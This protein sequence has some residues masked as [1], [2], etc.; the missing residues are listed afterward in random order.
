[1][2]GRLMSRVSP[3]VLFVIA[4]A[5]L[6]PPASTQ[7]STQK[8]QVFR[9]G[10]DVVPVYVNVR[11][12]ERGFVLDLTQD[13]F[14]L[15]DEGKP[16]KITQFTIAAQPL[17]TVVLIDG[18]ASMIP[19]F[20]RAVE[21]ARNFV[22][23]ML[24]EDR[25]KIG[26]FSDRVVLG[27]RFTSNRDELLKYLD[28][29]FNLRLGLDTHLWEALLESSMA[30]GKEEGKR[31]VVALT[32]GYNFVIP[33]GYLPPQTGGSAGGYPPTG[34]AGPGAPGTGGG[35]GRNPLGG[36]PLPPVLT[37]PTGAKPGPAGVG[38]RPPPPPGA[39]AGGGSIDPTTYG[40][41]VG[42]AE[43]VAIW[44][45][46]TIFA[47]SMWVRDGV[48]SQKP[49]LRL[50]QLALET[51]GAFYQV[52]ENDDMNVAFTDIVQ[53]LRQ[54]YVLG[55]TPAAFDGKRHKL[56]VRIKRRGLEVQARKSYI[57]ERS[58]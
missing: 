17:S 42:E 19:E 21:G 48:T 53:Q 1:M 28:N 4:L 34:P 25:T 3:G 55:F 10:T 35:T 22:L 24:P 32:D 8:P 40:V 47:V 9:A 7:T 23:R 45:T 54:Q 30:L 5:V 38:T 26:S 15:F 50:E 43:A 12:R 39:G 29:Q 2:V 52:R 6:S 18:S 56:E 31:V 51:G 46:V 33:P 14:E 41:Q 49:G 44:R 57:A 13:E 37:P 58:K 27:P 11:D 36:L 16:Q 20:T